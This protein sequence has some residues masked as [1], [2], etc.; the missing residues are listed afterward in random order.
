MKKITAIYVRRSVSD[1][2]KG[3]NSLSIDSQREECIKSLNN[4]EEYR[5]YCDDGKSGKNIE[6]R[7]AFQQMMSDA[8]DGLITR[9]I[10]KKYD[11]FSR[12]MREYLNVT[13]ELDRYGVS[14]ISLTEPFNTE[15]KEGRMM[16]N[17][18]LNFAEFERETIAARV[19]DAYSTRSLET[20]FYQGGKLYYGYIPERCTV[21]GKMGSVLVPSDKADVVKMAYEIY[22]ETYTSLQ[23][24]FNYFRENNINVNKS[25]KSNMDRSHFSRILQSPLYV[26]ADKDVYKYF[27]SKGYELIDDIEVFD[28][29]HGLFRHK[30][31]DSTEYIKVGYH[32]GLVDSETW[33]AVQDKKSHNQKIPNNT[34]AKNSWLVGLTKC[35]HCGYAFYIFYNWN[36][37]KTKRWRYYGDSGAYRADSCVK[38]RLKLKPDTVEQ[39]V[40]E[41]MKERLKNIVIAKAEKAKPDIESETINVEIIRLDNEIRKLL[42]K[43]AD[44]DAVLFNYIQD[45]VKTLH[46]KKSDLEEKLRTKARKYKEIDTTPLSDPMNRWDSLSLEEKH[47]LAVTMIDVVYV[48]DEKGIDITFII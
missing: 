31:S 37:A 48:S 22:K 18:L 2:D 39:V 26:R 45:R 43:L 25:Q 33:L 16:R 19:A 5:I 46:A 27:V 24:I 29:I 13:N 35:G 20:G 3:N 17:N 12:N 1:K 41:A 10:V 4:G 44:A 21:N 23:D 42:D 8:K 9:I 32:E 7:P 14:V 40:Y 30:R 47:A 11:R 28:G 36:T 6:Q 38:K 34:T 15:T